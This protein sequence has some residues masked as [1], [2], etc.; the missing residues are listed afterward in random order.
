MNDKEFN[1]QAAK[2]FELIS[3]ALVAGKDPSVHKERLARL[4][5]ARD[6]ERKKDAGTEG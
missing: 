4:F 5:E 1:E 6:K 3:A 2:L